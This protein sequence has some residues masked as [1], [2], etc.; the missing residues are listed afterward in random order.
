MSFQV[1]YTEIQ[2]TTENIPLRTFLTDFVTKVR[3]SHTNKGR[4]DYRKIKH[5]L[6][7]NGWHL[8]VNLITKLK[9]YPKETIAVMCTPILDSDTAI[10]FIHP[11][12]YLSIYF[13]VL[14]P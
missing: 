2:T 3:V 12:G 6:L 14:Q 9:L 5:A 1:A 7:K 4:D 8:P 11:N 13:R 10:L